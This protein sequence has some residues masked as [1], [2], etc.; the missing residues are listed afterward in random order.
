MACK[1]SVLADETNICVCCIFWCETDLCCVT[2]LIHLLKLMIPVAV[3]DMSIMLVRHFLACYVWGS[4]Y[5]YIKFLLRYALL[6][7]VSHQ[8]NSLSLSLQYQVPVVLMYVNIICLIVVNSQIKVLIQNSCNWAAF[9]ILWPI[10]WKISKNFQPWLPVGVPY[11][12][13]GAEVAV[14]ISSRS[15]LSAQFHF[16]SSTFSSFYTERSLA[17]KP[18]N[19]R[20]LTTARKVSGTWP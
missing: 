13:S 5:S 8:L 4:F 11:I 9:I 15:T 16:V 10:S 7:D 6:V 18:G 17:G 20:N 3:A 14:N 12:C 19:V 1:R 2:V